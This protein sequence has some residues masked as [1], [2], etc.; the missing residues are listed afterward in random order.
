MKCGR[1]IL[2]VLTAII[3]QAPLAYAGPI[4]IDIV[5]E[6]YRVS[7]CP[8][9]QEC[10]DISSTEPI[11]ARGAWAFTS[12]SDSQVVLET[13]V[14]QALLVGGSLAEVVFRSRAS[15]F[16]ETLVSGRTGT[17]SWYVR[18]QD[19]TTG[20]WL[21]DMDCG[22]AGGPSCSES[23][24]LWFVDGH[25]YK[26]GASVYTA[27]SEPMYARV[28]MPFTTAPDRSSTALLMGIG[29]VGVLVGVAAWRK[30]RQ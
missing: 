25:E 29:V 17:G 2:L 4:I 21:F 16:A 10:Y 7:G 18:L 3:V 6:A 20:D 15:G 9:S 19:I 26:L 22:G 1:V 30:R 27:D 11:H 28:I 5:S 12:V 14:T 13:Q 23:Y 24:S 8:Y